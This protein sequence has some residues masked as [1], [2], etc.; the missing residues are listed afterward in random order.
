MRTM[1]SFVVSPASAA[2]ESA[3]KSTHAHT[4]RNQLTAVPDSPV[5]AVLMTTW[6]P[7]RRYDL[8]RL[9]SRRRSELCD[10]YGAS[11][12]VF[13]KNSKSC[14]R[15]SVKFTASIDGGARK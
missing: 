7:F 9:L 3:A 10:H 13:L 14:G 4:A 8:L 6:L 1:Q 15:I 2:G 11:V 12:F 5:L